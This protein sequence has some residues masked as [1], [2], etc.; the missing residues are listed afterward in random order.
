[1]SIAMLRRIPLEDETSW[2]DAVRGLG[3]P[4]HSNAY[5]RALA[6]GASANPVLLDFRSAGGRLIVPVVERAAGDGR[7]LFT[8]YGLGGMIVDEPSPA[9]F[10][11]FGERM[12]ALGYVAGYF[13]LD[14]ATRWGEWTSDLDLRGDNEVFVVD[15]DAA[16]GHFIHP[17][18]DN[19][20][21]KLRE[22]DKANA[23]LET[24]S[25]Q[26][27]SAFLS[28]FP[29]TMDRVG[30]AA[31]YEFSTDRLTAL[32]E[33][34]ETL[35]YGGSVNGRIEAVSVFRR[36]AGRADYLFNASSGAGRAFS[37]KLLTVAAQQ[38]TAEGVGLFCLGG[39]IRRN[40]GLAQF[41]RRFGG[42]ALPLR[43]L[44]QVYD[45]ERFDRLCH[46]AGRVDDGGWFPP[47]Q[48]PGATVAASG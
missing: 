48:A 38:F 7:D 10:A 16:Q 15:L 12:R 28:L 30:A 19:L 36:W 8:P 31:T 47:Y 43:A 44:C 1:M 17:S 21:A 3:W 2:N 40:D 33:D 4:A 25:D 35:I 37:A 24:A 22:W 42:T 6:V 29:A 11:H 13:Q 41:K 34:S 39:G 18:S 23:R 27:K 20:K 46:A 5:H 45:R 9:L 14:I 32:L 26:L